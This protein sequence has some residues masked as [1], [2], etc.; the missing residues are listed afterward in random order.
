MNKRMSRKSVLETKAMA[1]IER[2]VISDY[3]HLCIAEGRKP[4]DAFRQAKRKLG[5]VKNP[6]I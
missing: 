4:F 1:T 3:V 6:K 2:S 5:T